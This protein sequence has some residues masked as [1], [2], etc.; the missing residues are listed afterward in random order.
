MS[1]KRNGVTLDFPTRLETFGSR[2]NGGVL[3]PPKSLG[4]RLLFVPRPAVLPATSRELRGAR[5]TAIITSKR[6][7]DLRL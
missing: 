7:A 5:A 1:L 4:S 3:A 6:S 2:R